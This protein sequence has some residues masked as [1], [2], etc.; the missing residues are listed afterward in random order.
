MKGSMG[1]SD[2][3]LLDLVLSEGRVSGVRAYAVLCTRQHND[4]V[5][6]ARLRMQIANLRER[7]R[8]LSKGG[9][10][11]KAALRWDSRQAYQRLLEL[12]WRLRARAKV[13]EDAQRHL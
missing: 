3:D 11:E 5:E 1:S 8:H 10:R 12:R 2:R 9:W 6:L 7:R 13:L 4:R